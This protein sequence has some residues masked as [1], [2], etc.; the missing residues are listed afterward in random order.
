MAAGPLYAAGL[1]GS[2]SSA[3]FACITLLISFTDCTPVILP[4]AGRGEL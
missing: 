4:N 3:A 2:A 1:S